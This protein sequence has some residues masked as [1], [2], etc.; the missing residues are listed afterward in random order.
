MQDKNF[1]FFGS[2]LNTALLLILI[3]LMIIALNFMYGNRELFQKAVEKQETQLSRILI[4][5]NTKDLVLL[6]VQPGQL[7]SG[8]MK[9]AGSVQG[10][11][12]FEANIGINIL[13]ANKSVIKRGNGTAT[14]EWMTIDPVSF[15][16][17]V[18]FTGLTKGP[19]FLEIHNDNASGLKENDKSILIP[20]VIN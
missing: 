17:D 10:A 18:D 19:A 8:K 14:T 13:D 5:G 1:W 2:K 11:Y 15:T 6:N 20:I 12:F 3:I 16:A 4:S 7:V 9:V